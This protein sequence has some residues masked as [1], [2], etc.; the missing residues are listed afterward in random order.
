MLSPKSIPI[1]SSLATPTPPAAPRPGQLWLSNSL[2][3]MTVSPEAND[4][5]PIVDGT[6]DATE[7]QEPS[8]WWANGVWNLAYTAGAIKY[9]S[10]AGDPTVK[11]NWSAPTNL[12][13]AGVN[14]VA[15][16]VARCYVAQFGATLYYYFV[17]LTAS[18]TWYVATAPAATPTVVTVLGAVYTLPDGEAFAGN[19]AVVYDAGAGVYR[20]FHERLVSVPNDPALGGGTIFT[21]AVGMLT[22]A[23][24]TGTF[25]QQI[26]HLETL[27]VKGYSSVS[28][29]DMHFENGVWVMYYHAEEWANSAPDNIYRAISTTLAADAWTP[30]A[31][32]SPVI[33]RAHAYESGPAD[34]GPPRGPPPRS[35]PLA[36][37][38]CSRPC[39]TACARPTGRNGSQRTGRILPR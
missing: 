11:A 38:S 7:Y 17:E 13:G 15:Y 30:L 20:M 14:G 27:R 26:S 3:H 39:P 31:N 16:T 37:R 24:P 29:P 6:I 4:R 19:S 8:L 22:C 18:T 9:R 33:R 32:S 28:G 12:F 2:Q 1:S 25:A 23:T 10:C 34:S 35:E 5:V 21:W 36:A